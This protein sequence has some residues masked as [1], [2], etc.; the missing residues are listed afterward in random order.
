MEKFKLWDM[1]INSFC[2]KLEKLTTEVKKKKKK[3][4]NKRFKRNLL[5]KFFLVGVIR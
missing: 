1:P 3:K 5:R 4:I 2:Q